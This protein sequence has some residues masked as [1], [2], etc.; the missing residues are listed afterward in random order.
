MIKVTVAKLVGAYEVL[1]KIAN[2]TLPARE[3]W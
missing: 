2:A 3:S 1:Q